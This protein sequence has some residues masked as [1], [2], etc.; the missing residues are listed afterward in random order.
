MPCFVLY[1]R[2][3]IARWIG[4]KFIDFYVCVLCVYIEKEWM[5]YESRA[6]RISLLRGL[7]FYRE[8]STVEVL[9]LKY[10]CT[11]NEK[12]KKQCTYTQIIRE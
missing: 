11:E 7:L 5:E 9:L 4:L 6:G 12:T 10:I 2:D 1:L 8:N 3:A